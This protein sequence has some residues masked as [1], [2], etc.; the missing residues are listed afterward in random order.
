MK[1]KDTKVFTH[2]SKEV[3]IYVGNFLRYDET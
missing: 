3:K 2:V 1:V